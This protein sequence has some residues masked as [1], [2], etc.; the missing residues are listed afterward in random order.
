[1]SKDYVPKTET[2]VEQDEENL[3]YIEIEPVLAYT[4]MKND[5]NEILLKDSVS[6]IRSDHK[7]FIF[8]F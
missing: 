8:G 7:V 2:Q 1:M 5:V 4:R 6:C 3:E